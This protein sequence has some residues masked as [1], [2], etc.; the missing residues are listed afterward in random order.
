MTEFIIAVDWMNE[1]AANSAARTGGENIMR[2]VI[3][4]LAVLLLGGLMTIISAAA[5]GVNLKLNA[6]LLAGGDVV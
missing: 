2:S 1:R 3:C 4:P 6:A 5:Q